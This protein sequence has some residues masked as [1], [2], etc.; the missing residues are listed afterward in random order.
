ME[1]AIAFFEKLF[2]RLLRDGDHATASANASTRGVFA[3]RFDRLLDAVVVA[4]YATPR[5]RRFLLLQTLRS[6]RSVSFFCPPVLLVRGVRALPYA[7]KFFYS[8]DDFLVR[9]SG[10]ATLGDSAGSPAH[11]CAY[12]CCWSSSGIDI[13]GDCA[14]GVPRFALGSAEFPRGPKNVL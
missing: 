9:S 2:S 8:V 11:H 12:E 4:D 5:E 1:A 10:Q 14:C 13:P 3:I 6:F 7:N